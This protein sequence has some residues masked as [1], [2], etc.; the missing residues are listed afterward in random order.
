MKISKKLIDR[1]YRTLQNSPDCRICVSRRNKKEG[2]DYCV[3]K[4]WNYSAFQIDRELID[5]IVTKT[6]KNNKDVE[7]E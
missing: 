1:F 4:C 3:R 5:N 7:D 2:N 6:L